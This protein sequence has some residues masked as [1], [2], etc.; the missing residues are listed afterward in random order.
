MSQTTLEDDFRSFAQ[1]ATSSLEAALLVARV[2]EPETD[3]GWCRAELT[4]L[5][6]T[7]DE[8]ASPAA[9][10]ES[11]SKAG[12]GGAEQYYQMENSVLEHVLRNRSGIPITLA[13][14]IIG[15]A[16]SLGLSACGVNFPRH[17]LVAFGELLVDPFEMR[18]LDPDE[19]RNLVAGSPNGADHVL[20]IASPRDVALRMLNN[21][22]MIALSAHDHE[23]AL[24]FTDFQ[25]LVAEQPFAVRVDRADLWLALGSRD[26]AQQEL[27]RALSEAPSA[28]WH[29]RIEHRLRQL[30]ESPSTLH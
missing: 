5:A 27:T 6:Q 29:E 15:V 11:L 20:A 22:R 24:R 25:L 23:Q 4:R 28:A 18:M 10:I 19:T 3:V 14:V 7:C 17:F 21:L 26:L 9:V 8:P 1:R 13:M 12:F 16:E 2:V 30:G